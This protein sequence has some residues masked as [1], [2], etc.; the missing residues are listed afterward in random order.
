M[1]GIP[2][3]A[4]TLKR[5]SKYGNVRC[6][7]DGYHFDSQRERDHYAGNLKLRLM[8]GEIESLTVHPVSDLIVNGLKVGTYEP[9]FEY[10]DKRTGK[11]HI[12]DV[13][14]GKGGKNAAT[15]TL[16]SKIKQL[17]FKALYGV[18]VE[19]VT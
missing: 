10:R 8:A 14:G 7:L 15:N 19:I 5:K 1:A 9:D 16:L 12:I 11:V 3:L 4:G 6:E 2:A 13:K 17:I 18:E